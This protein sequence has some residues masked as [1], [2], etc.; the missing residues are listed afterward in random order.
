VPVVAR[1]SITPVK[2]LALHH[3]DD[4]RLEECGV[5]ENRRFYLVREDGRLF[6]GVHHGRLVQV[7]ADYDGAHDHLSLRFPDGAVVE[8]DIRLDGPVV[9]DF[10]G[11]RVRGRLVEGPWAQALSAFAGHPLQLVKADRPGGG[12]DVEPVTLVSR[13][14]VEELAR[15]A[16][17]GEVDSRRFRMLIELD[18]CNPHEEDSWAGRRVRVGAAFVEI[19]GPVPRCA[20]TTRDPATGVRD[21]DALRAI[22]AYRGLRD[23]KKVDFGVYARV[24]EP[25]RVRVGDAVQPA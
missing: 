23:G 15:R 5:A 19:L 9:T 8:N 24:L 1:L 14:S 4:V 16:G 17:R 6:A 20:T 12:S 3:P 2:S 11:H 25:G 10:W 22:R 21:F 7:R 13:A 18:G